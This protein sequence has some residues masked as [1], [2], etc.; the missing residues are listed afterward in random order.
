MDSRVIELEK[1]NEQLKPV[2]EDL[3][4]K[5]L[6]EDFPKRFDFMFLTDRPSMYMPEDWDGASN[7]NFDVTKRDKFFQKLLIKHGAAGRYAT[8][9]VKK[10]D[11]A[12]EKPNSKEI[13]E[14]L[15]FLFKEIEIIEPK[16]IILIGKWAEMIFW[17]YI[18]YHIPD[19]IKTDW[20]WHYNQPWNIK[21]DYEI[22]KRFQDVVRKIR[23]GN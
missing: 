6:P 5:F 1:L 13:L 10:R 15:P 2:P 14:Y 8:D 20:V 11:L 23:N 9:I 22:E 21:T 12:S 18:W 17:E 19:G 4:G 3:P 16:G 7:Y